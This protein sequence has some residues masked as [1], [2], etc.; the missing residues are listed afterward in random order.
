MVKTSFTAHN[1]QFL[2]HL[3]KSFIG[4]QV[5][6]IAYTQEEV[7]NENTAQKRAFDFSTMKVRTKDFRFN[8]DEANERFASLLR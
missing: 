4:K 1:Q 2:L 8:R 7:V 3:P 6:I 5:E